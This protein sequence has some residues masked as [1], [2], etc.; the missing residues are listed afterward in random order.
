[1]KSK[2]ILGLI[3][4]TVMLF[5]TTVFADSSY[6]LNQKRIFGG[7]RYETSALISKNGWE[8]ASTVVICNGENFPDALC[9]APLAKKYNAPILLTNKSDLSESTKKELSRLNPSKIIIIGGSGVITDTVV[10]EIKT[11]VPKDADITRLGGATRYDTSKIIADKVG[12]SSSIVLVSGKAPADALSISYIAANKG[13]PILLADNK[14]SILDYSKNNSVEKAYIIGGES[15]ISKDIDSIFKNN[16]RIYGKDRYDSNEKI[17]EKFKDDINFSN[18]YLAS[19]EYNGIDQFADALSVS[20]LA[21]K[22]CNPIILVNGNINKDSVSIIK[23]KVN[24]DSKITALGGTQLVAENILADLANVKSSNEE[25]KPSKSSSGGSGG[26]GGSSSSTYTFAGGNGTVSSPYEIASAAQLNKV[27]DYLDKNFVLTADIDLSS[28]ANWEPIGTFKPISDKPEDEETPDPKAAFRGSFNG[29]GHTISNLKIDRK[30]MGIGLFGC[31][32]QNENKSVV[33]HNLIVKNVSVTGYNDLIGGV[34]GHQA[35]G[36]PIEKI[37]LIGDNKITGNDKS[38]NVGGIVGGAMD[39]NITD[40]KSEANIIVNG[41]GNNLVGILGGGLGNC[42]LSGCSAKGSI[43]VNGKEVYSIGGLAGCI[44]EGAYV[45]NCS[46]DVTI[47]AAE[48]DFMIGG[49]IG[50]A[51]TFDENGPTVISNCTVKANIKAAENA[52]RI[53]GV[54]GS[55]FYIDGF[56]YYP[57]PSVYK[58]ENCNTEGSIVGGKEVGTVAGY[59]YNSVLEN[60]TSTMTINDKADASQIGKSDTEASLF[61]GGSGTKS[62]PYQI[63]NASQL[64]KVRRYLNK[65]YILTKDIDLSTYENW[66]PIG[67]FKP[68]SDKPEDEETPNINF[69]FSGIFN[70]NGHKISNIHISRDNSSGVGL[71]GCV[72]GDNAFIQNLVVENVTASGKQLVGAVIGYGSFKNDAE[73]ISLIGKNS[74]KGGFLVGGIVGGGFCNIKNCNANADVILIGDNAQGIGVL[75]GGMEACSLISCSATG[76]VT[77]SGNGN[78]SIAGLSGAAQESPSVENC[79]ADVTIIVGENSS[80]VGGLL[81]NAGTY[82]IEKPTLIKNCYANASIKATDSSERI[83]GIVGGGFYLDAY[84]AVRPVP[85][86][87]KIVDSKTSGSIDGGKIVGSIAGHA[88]NSIVENCTST[89]TV[90]GNSNAV[91][92]G[93]SETVK[94]SSFAGGSGTEVDPYQIATVD[95]LNNVRK[96]LDKH[97][98]LIADI[99]LASYE[100]WEPIG[101]FDSQAKDESGYFGNAFKGTFDG[102]GHTISNLVINKK[103]VVGVGLIG[104]TSKSS[105]IKNL[106]VENVKAEGAVAVGSVAGYNRGTVENI[107]LSGT[108]TIAAYSCAGGVVGGNEGGTIKNCNATDA[109]INMLDNISY[110]SP[111]VSEWKTNIDNVGTLVV[112]FNNDGTAATYLNGKAAES[113]KYFAYKGLYFVLDDNGNIEKIAKYKFSDDGKTLEYYGLDNN[114]MI[115]YQKSE[116]LKAAS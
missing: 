58:V 22:N 67:E 87:Y 61:A 46:S 74:I 42:S 96:Y 37:E 1:M 56:E 16:E 102:D 57:T 54:V 71:F 77:A 111:F 53:G 8:T 36:S 10:S 27:R 116:S 97:F 28:Y 35:A 78:F 14:D 60:C 66:E 12:K 3:V 17:L 99:D 114:L 101:A 21:A 50:H 26:S 15:V 48:K 43:T 34:I 29:N 90:N 18:I 104:V 24:K 113:F 62:D 86:V 63:D 23:S 84:K 88:Y 98:K 68:V 19:A 94:T 41:D 32:T 2:R 51:G 13:M 100:N 112:D 30:N 44:H 49:L 65:N 64:N 25:K 75:A 108:N 110:I 9:A 38:A 73:S 80:M 70:G 93:K 85:T 82:D 33:I 6:S 115:S 47:S 20:A 40:C 45:K 7:D 81:G 109:T 5:S 72:A 59:A 95:Q 11:I 103:D 107:T 106:K 91:Q 52:S 31:I 76:T 79:N 55:G 92:I 89:M 39:S 105:L 4:S 83:G 69:A